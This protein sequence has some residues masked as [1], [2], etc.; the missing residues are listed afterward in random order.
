MSNSFTCDPV[1]NAL[2]KMKAS[3]P[4][5][6]DDWRTPKD[7]YDKLNKRFNFDFDPCPFQ[8]DMSWNGLTVDWGQVNFVNPPYSKKLKEAFVKKAILESRKGKVCVLL[9]PVSTGTKLFHDHILPE[10]PKIEFIK[11]RLR[12]EGYNNR[13]EFCNQPSM[14][15]SMLVIFGYSNLSLQ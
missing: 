5:Q 15:D 12:F 13:G 4:K 10:E 6:P 3:R 8:H 14:R 9:I 11:G 7:F 2:V 1:Y